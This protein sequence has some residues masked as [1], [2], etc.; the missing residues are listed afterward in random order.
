MYYLI[1]ISAA[2]EKFTEEQLDN[3]LIKSRSNNHK[4]G[5]TGILVYHDGHILQLLEG[6]KDTVVSKYHDITR[7]KRHRGMMIMEDGISESRIFPDWSMGYRA[8]NESEYKSAD[9]FWHLD[10]N[11]FMHDH[12]SSSQVGNRSVLLWLR[13][14][15]AGAMRKQ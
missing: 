3:I 10:D 1:Y 9:G 8:L 12:S 15:T 2:T 6:E 13:T 7:D 4:L 5:L 14:F 11:H